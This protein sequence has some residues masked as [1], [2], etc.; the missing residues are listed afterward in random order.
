MKNINSSLNRCFEE[1]HHVLTLDDFAAL[2]QS[3]NIIEKM[4]KLEIE[5][6]EYCHQTRLTDSVPFHISNQKLF[7][8][9]NT[10]GTVGTREFVF[11]TILYQHLFFFIATPSF[12]QQ[13]CKAS[14]TYLDIEWEST[15]Y[16]PPIT[17]YILELKQSNNDFS[18]VCFL[19]LVKKIIRSIKLVLLFKTTNSLQI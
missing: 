2:S 8:M 15:K 17:A 13:K 7:E 1:G 5:N 4:K 6:N 12:V 14:C 19:V 9:I 16:N 11:S 10:S 3:K 18:E